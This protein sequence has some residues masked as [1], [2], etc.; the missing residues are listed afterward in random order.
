M[1]FLMFNVVVFGALF[2]L[3]TEDKVEIVAVTDN[4]HAMVSRAGTLVNHAV[5]KVNSMIGK[6]NPPVDNAAIALERPEPPV[7]IKEQ[8]PVPTIPMSAPPVRNE[9]VAQDSASTVR[10]S[11]GAPR[12][13]VSEQSVEPPTRLAA[14]E[15]PQQWVPQRTVAKVDPTVSEQL[16]AAG[17]P[18]P[19]APLKTTVEGKPEIAIAPGEILMTPRERRK[20]LAV[21][22]EDMELLSLN[23]LSK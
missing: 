5:E 11:P 22:A 7:E 23:K 1:R 16:L 13:K 8:G 4:A 15:L 2:Y 12:T 9:M 20:E 18:V 10:V 19:E 21:L 3:F 17:N 14:D 6:E